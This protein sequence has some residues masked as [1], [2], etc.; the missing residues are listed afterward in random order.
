MITKENFRIVRRSYN[1]DGKYWHS[2]ELK[3][4]K[5]GYFF[6]HEE[7]INPHIINRK[8]KE[9]CESWITSIHPKNI[10]AIKNCGEKILNRLNNLQEGE[11]IVD[12]QEYENYRNYLRQLKESDKYTYLD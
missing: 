1:V 2:P 12:Y 11:E 6:K 4:I 3:I 5:Q 9:L 8:N 7:W 10:N